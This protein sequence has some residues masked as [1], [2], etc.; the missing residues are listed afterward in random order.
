MS[1]GRLDP[2]WRLNVVIYVLQA[3]PDFPKPLF[4]LERSALFHSLCDSETTLFRLRK[5]EAPTPIPRTGW[6]QPVD[7]SRLGCQQNHECPG[8]NRGAGKPA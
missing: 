6:T 8:A 7:N 3:G 5:P 4:F 1:A 2:K